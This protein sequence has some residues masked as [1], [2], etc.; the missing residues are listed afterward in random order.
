MYPTKPELLL[1]ISWTVWEQKRVIISVLLYQQSRWWPWENKIIS[2]KSENSFP[3]QKDLQTLGT[4]TNYRRL[5]KKANLGQL[6][7][8]IDYF[9]N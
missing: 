8:T 2:G 4:N 5:Q 3:E 6:S 7:N 9:F 1:L